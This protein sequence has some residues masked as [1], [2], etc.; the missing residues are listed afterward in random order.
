MQRVLLV[1]LLAVAAMSLPHQVL[2]FDM[3]STPETIP[4]TAT[5]Y[6]D[7]D[8]NLQ[9]TPPNES[10]G[11]TTGDDSSSASPSSGTLQLAPGT[12]LQ[13]MGGTGPTLGLESGFPL[14]S[15]VDASNPADN[16]KLI[17]SP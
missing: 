17:P 7:P 13:I 10:V 1:S 14:A 11:M 8:D 9:L 3:E 6:Q 5:Q 12:T 4:G 16:Q 2:A 15:P